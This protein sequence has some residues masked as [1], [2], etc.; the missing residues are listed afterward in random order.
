[1]KRMLGMVAL[2]MVLILT[3]G[4]LSAGS[5]K[6]ATTYTLG[7]QLSY[8][9]GMTTISWTRSGDS[10][11]VKV[12]VRAIDNGS[13][14]QTLWLVGTTANTFVTTDVCLPGYRYRV[15]LCDLD[16]YVLEEKDYDMPAP[17]TFSDGNLKNTSVKVQLETR[18]APYGTRTYNTEKKLS[19]AKIERDMND[20]T[21]WY[22]VKFL[23]QMPRLAKPR[24]FFVTLAFESPE[25]YI[26]VET[27]QDITF[28][29]VNGGYQ[30]IWW[31]LIGTG[32]FRDMLGKTGHIPAGRYKTILYWDGMLVNESTF[33]VGD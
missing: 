26:Y 28:D 24:T 6:A 16:D 2:M 18:S 27:A 15:L 22:G 5:A 30:T 23:M 19:A 31:E 3:V 4:C 13:S 32:F 33:A 10:E 9:T 29:R 14:D 20:Y 12:Y 11:Q 17:V 21:T 25:G 1:M 8:D 7:N